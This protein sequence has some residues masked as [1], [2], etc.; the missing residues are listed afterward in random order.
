MKDTHM[1]KNQNLTIKISGKRNS[2]FTAYLT[3][4]AVKMLNIEKASPDEKKEKLG[5]L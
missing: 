5:A 3:K 4:Q 1:K 2:M